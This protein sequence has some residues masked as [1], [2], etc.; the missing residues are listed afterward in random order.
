M[1]EYY[2]KIPPNIKLFEETIREKT[3]VDKLLLNI[4]TMFT[5]YP[6][7]RLKT[8]K[9]EADLWIVVDKMSRCF[10]QN[11]NSIHTFNIPFLIE[12]SNDFAYF[13]YESEMVD[14]KMCSFMKLL[15][16]S[17]EKLN[18]F[19]GIFDSF[20]DIAYDEYKLDDKHL[21]YYWRAFMELLQFDSGYMRYDHDIV[22]A[23]IQN[24]PEYHIDF[25]YSSNSTFK[26]GLSN[27]IDIECLRRIVDVNDKCYYINL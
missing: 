15:F 17:I 21:I 2:I 5:V 6:L 10:V 1:K 27:A 25:F 26:M 19:D 3:S 24:H 11:G 12:E 14:N 22:N 13:N 4:V 20:T 8:T 9:N 16:N 18:S 23:D 7:S